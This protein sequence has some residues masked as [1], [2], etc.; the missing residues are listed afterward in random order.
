MA[1][2]LITYLLQS[3][4]CFSLLFVPFQFMLK[5]DRHFH[6]NRALLI[7]IMLSGLL[8][9]LLPH[10]FP[11]NFGLYYTPAESSTVLVDI[12]G[13][14]AD[15]Q[16]LQAE[17]PS[18][19]SI[20]SLLASV[21]LVG[22]LA[23]LI[24]QITAFTRL[25]LHIRRNHA[26]KEQIGRST[27]LFHINSPFPS[28]SWMN[29]I[30]IS[31]EDLQANGDVILTHEQAHVDYRHSWDK[32]LM[33]LCQVIQWFNPLVWL[34]SDTLNEIHEYEADAAV[35]KKG[36]DMKQYQYLLISKATGPVKLAIVNGLGFNKLKLRIMMM[37]NTH[38]EGL[39]W[40]KY[41]TLLPMMLI[42]FAVSARNAESRDVTP[43]DAN[44]TERQHLSADTV[45][46][47]TIVKIDESSVKKK[48]QKAQNESDGNIDKM[49]EFPGGLA[50]LKSFI[51]QNIKFPPSLKEAGIEGRV[52]AK[53]VVKAD[54]T[55]ADTEVLKSPHELFTEE[56]LRIIR[57]MP[58][59][60]PGM[61]GGKPIDVAFTIPIM[62]KNTPKKQANT[63]VIKKNFE[64]SATGNKI[65]VVDGK[66]LSTEN[67][68][69]L[70]QINPQS[71]EQIT[72]VKSGEI[73]EKYCEETGKKADAVILITRTKGK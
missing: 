37:N 4:I 66:V 45:R 2:P 12:S 60:E 54:G 55:I 68:E 18:R 19:F 21:W 7:L 24:F 61:S 52:I 23:I 35:V 26:G 48:Q 11:V 71:I 33:I 63:L 51:G 22:V 49:P 14:S 39:S 6:L 59:W 44:A 56:A 17:A 41:A 8:L 58:K 70:N 67:L 42:A 43:S 57:L 3:A 64:K 9:P 30:Y 28:F 46:T 13:I 36:F 69:E 50:E 34:L 40:P 5:S 53:F 62:F 73:Y 65:I 27:Y 32:I 72:V 16:S 47:Q 15:A 20:T 1:E 38:K 25:L 10:T 31:E 29:N